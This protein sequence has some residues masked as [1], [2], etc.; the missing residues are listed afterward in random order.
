MNS[1]GT[2]GHETEPCHCGLWWCKGLIHARNR[3]NG[4]SH[5]CYIGNL[6]F[7]A[8][9]P[10]NDGQEFTEQD[11]KNILAKFG[12]EAMPWQINVMTVVLNS[13]GQLYPAYRKAFAHERN[14]TDSS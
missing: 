2:C 1:C 8:K 14:E 10:E 5:F 9:P 11:V 12:I 13:D 7:I 6:E 4:G 3:A